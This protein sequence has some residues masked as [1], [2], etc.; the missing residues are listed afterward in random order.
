MTTVPRRL[1]GGFEIRSNYCGSTGCGRR[2]A[3]GNPL[4]GLHEARIWSFL[5]SMLS[6]ATA[7]TLYYGSGTKRHDNLLNAIGTPGALEVHLTSGSTS[8]KMLRKRS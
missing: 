4:K 6:Y 3:S 8:P 7:A 1:T 5:D 2:K